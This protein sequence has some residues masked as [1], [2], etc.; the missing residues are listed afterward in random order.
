MQ[1][2]PHTHKTHFGR[3]LVGG[4]KIRVCVRVPRFAATASS[5]PGT[6]IAPHHRKGV[7]CMVDAQFVGQFVDS[8]CCWYVQYIYIY[9]RYVL[10]AFERHR[11]TAP[12]AVTPF[13]VQNRWSL[14][15]MQSTVDENAY[16][17]LNN[18]VR[19]VCAL[20]DDNDN[21]DAR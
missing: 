20:R 16:S 11:N 4:F 13:P 6:C 19:P 5:R 14:S 3:I 2:G 8:I 21:K 18:A 12:R 10:C 7:A 9:V 15:L 17:D 1:N